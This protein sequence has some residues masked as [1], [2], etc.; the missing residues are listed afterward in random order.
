MPQPKPALQSTLQPAL[1]S[2]IQNLTNL[3]NISN[4]MYPQQF[5]YNPFDQYNQ[6]NQFNYPLHLS[7]STD[8]DS[9]SPRSSKRR[10]KLKELYAEYRKLKHKVISESDPKYNEYRKKKHQLKKQIKNLEE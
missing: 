4:L 7:S 3:S 1:Q 8:L 9:V 10:Q 2:N 5:L 6:Y